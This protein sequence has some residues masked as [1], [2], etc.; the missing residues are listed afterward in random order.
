MQLFCCVEMQKMVLAEDTGESHRIRPYNKDH[1]NSNISKRATIQIRLWA[2]T[3]WSWRSLNVKFLK[4]PKQGLLL[5]KN[6]C[7]APTLH[8]G[9][10]NSQSCTCIQVSSMMRSGD[11]SGDWRGG[12]KGWINF[13]TTTN[14][15][16]ITNMAPALFAVPTDRSHQVQ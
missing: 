1:V 8:F 5:N 3:G 11:V 12:G 16:P 2:A 4:E 13:G 6:S 9:Y 15:L 10:L 14:P 7:F